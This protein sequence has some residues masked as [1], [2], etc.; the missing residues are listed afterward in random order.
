MARDM[1][2]KIS[3]QLLLTLISLA[4]LV[5]IGLG[6]RD[7]PTSCDKTKDPASCHAKG[8]SVSNKAQAGPR[9][10]VSNAL[11][12]ALTAAKAATA[13]LS[14]ASPDCK[15]VMSSSQESL[16]KSIGELDKINASN[17]AMSVS[18]I[19]TWV[20][21]ALTSQTTCSDGLTQSAAKA[22][23]QK[24]IQLTKSALALVNSN[25]SRLV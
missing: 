9:V 21:A 22:Q 18:N 20:S 17:A 2:N 1:T 23:I 15:E 7:E 19:Q 8:L 16:S 5:N 3:V 24:V 6:G 14:N 12:A 25:Y 11:N 10:T 4:C 13:S